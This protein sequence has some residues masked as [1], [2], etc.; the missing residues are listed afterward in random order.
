MK[1][2][3]TTSF[4]NDSMIKMVGYDMAVAASKEVYEKSGISPKE[5]DV[6]ELHDCFTANELLTYEALGLAAKGQGGAYA[7]SGA[8]A[9]DGAVPVNTGGELIGFG[10]PVGATGVKQPLEIF[11]QMKGLCGSY[12]VQKPLRYGITSNMGGDDK[13]VVSLVLKNG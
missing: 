8:T 3:F 5:V 9:L 7:R 6:V 2:D 12:Q 4:Q 11:R 1:T 10:H 13:T